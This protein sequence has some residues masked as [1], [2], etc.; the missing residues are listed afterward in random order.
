MFMPE[1]HPLPEVTQEVYQPVKSQEVCPLVVPRILIWPTS[2][3]RF[4]MTMGTL[5]RK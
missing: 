5:P 4:P 3:F 2:A 1:P